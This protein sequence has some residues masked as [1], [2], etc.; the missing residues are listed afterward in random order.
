MKTWFFKR[1]RC[2]VGSLPRKIIHAVNFVFLTHAELLFICRLAKSEKSISPEA[3][4][5]RPFFN[6]FAR[7]FLNQTISC[8]TWNHFSLAF[9]Q[10]PKRANHCS[11]VRVYCDRANK[12]IRQFLQLQVTRRKVTAWPFAC[13]LAGNTPLAFEIQAFPASTRKPAGTILNKLC[14]RIRLLRMFL[15]IDSETCA[16][17][18]TLFQHALGLHVA[19]LPRLVEIITILFKTFGRLVEAK[20]NASERNTGMIWCGV[21]D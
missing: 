6:I 15:K 19:G 9:P 2:Y 21:I 7:C 16:R 11:A 12:T 14:P 10:F 3:F 4:V 8:N 1:V 18:G 20:R 13:W 17:L 5:V